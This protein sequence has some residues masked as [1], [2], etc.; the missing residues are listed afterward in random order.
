MK[1]KN[2]ILIEF[3]IFSKNITQKTQLKPLG[4]SFLDNWIKLKNRERTNFHK[5]NIITINNLLEV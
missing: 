5:V 1:K 4:Q 2:Y 3:F